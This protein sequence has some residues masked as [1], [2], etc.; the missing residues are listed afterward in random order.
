LAPS[1][2]RLEN[3]ELVNADA[4]LTIPTSQEYPSLNLSHAVGLMAYEWD[5]ASMKKAKKEENDHT[6]ASK[7]QL[8][9]TFS[10][11]EEAL[12]I[13]A[14][15]SKPLAKKPYRWRQHPHH[16]HRCRHERARSSNLA[17]DHPCSGRKN[18]P[19]HVSHSEVNPKKSRESS[20]SSL[21]MTWFLPL[22][23]ELIYGTVIILSHGAVTLV[24]GVV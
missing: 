12:G 3:E 14:S 5:K 20:R 4:I 1:A 6:P 16:P 23:R 22:R 19:H 7:E 2:W 10:Q 13:G 18:N 15:I 24:N 9:G 11:L 17:R 21:T 8:E